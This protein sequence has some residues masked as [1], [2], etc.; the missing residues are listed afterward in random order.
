MPR[1]VV[2]R[3]GAGPPS[4][5]TGMCGNRSAAQPLQRLRLPAGGTSIAIQSCHESE[6]VH[7]T[8]CGVLARTA[9]KWHSRTLLAQDGVVKSA[10]SATFKLAFTAGAVPCTSRGIRGEEGSVSVAC[11]VCS[12]VVPGSVCPLQIQGAHSGLRP[13][14]ALRRPRRQRQ[15]VCR[16]HLCL[17]R[18]V[19]PT[20][21]L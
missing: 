7:Y 1:H 11:E 9:R 3:S 5:C 17:W 15:A 18:Q 19:A 21:H 12:D 2:D 16:M 10:T 14:Q 6:C 8:H 20:S 4:S 13:G